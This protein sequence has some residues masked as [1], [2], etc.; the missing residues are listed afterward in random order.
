MTN[1][2]SQR[3]GEVS[4]GN[5]DNIHDFLMKT[6]RKTLFCFEEH[7]LLYNLFT[8]CLFGNLETTRVVAEKT[9]VFISVFYFR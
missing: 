9:L 5:E 2:I 1:Q 7:N 3:E 6:K 4:V 8:Y